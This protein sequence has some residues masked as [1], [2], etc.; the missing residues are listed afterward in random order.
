MKGQTRLNFKQFHGMKLPVLEFQTWFL[1]TYNLQIL[2][3]KY[4]KRKFA[5]KPNYFFFSN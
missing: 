2:I 4:L 3:I 1:D 5:T